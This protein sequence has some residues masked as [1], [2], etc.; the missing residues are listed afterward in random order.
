MSDCPDC[1]RARINPNTGRFTA[2]CDGCAA[3]ALARTPQ[4]FRAAKEGRF[5]PEYRAALHQM[6]PKLTQAE[7]H[8]M[9]KG[10]TE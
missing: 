5:T 2:H 9:V 8:A 10:W 4:F 1:A 7:A 6:L 3:R